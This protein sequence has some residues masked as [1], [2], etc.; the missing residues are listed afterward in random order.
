MNKRGLSGIVVILF[1]LMVSTGFYIVLSGWFDRF[2]DEMK[3]EYNS[4][5]F[6]NSIEI[7]KIRGTDLYVKNDYKDN[8]LIDSIL[9]GETYCNILPVEIDKGNAVIDIGSCTSGFNELS[10]V[11][12]SLITS[13]GVYNQVQVLED[14]VNNSLIVKYVMGS[15]DFANGYIRLFGL[16]DLDNAHIEID[17]SSTYSVCVKDLDYI[18]SIGSGG[19]VSQD[20]FYLIGTNNSAVW[21][22]KG[23]VLIEPTFWED[24]VISSSGGI[25]GYQISSTQP[26]NKYV[27]LGSLDIDNVYGS[28]FGDCDSSLPDKIWIS[29]E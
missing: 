6:Y 1:L 16:T 20:I 13:S 21:T 15:C 19:S 22:D 23:S 3:V 28:H 4:P 10:P 14:P 29:L 7:S 17:G 5:D 9:V 24:V 11:D 25:F 26:S 8:L 2:S 27:C 12:I 18:L